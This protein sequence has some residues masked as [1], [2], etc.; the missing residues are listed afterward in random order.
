MSKK[1]R[2]ERK[3]QAV[4]RI[5]WLSGIW[6]T[7]E[8]KWLLS[9]SFFTNGKVL[10]EILMEEFKPAGLQETWA[11]K[12]RQKMTFSG[13][14]Q[15]LR[16]CRKHQERK[17][18]NPRLR[19]EFEAFDWDSDGQ[20]RLE[21]TEKICISDESFSKA[22]WNYRSFEPKIDLDNSPN[23]PT[24]KSIKNSKRSWKEGIKA[25]KTEKCDFG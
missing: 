13:R 16:F 2:H 19:E 24:R 12:L 5:S 25:M 4:F 23:Q 21:S 11:W 1:N 7:E 3:P 17:I 9:R 22:L 8:D 18:L 6:S 10:I 20:I 15:L 14:S